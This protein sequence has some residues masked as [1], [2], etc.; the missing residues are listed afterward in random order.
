[1]KTIGQVIE[2]LFFESGL[3][4]REF[5]EKVGYSR[6]Y[7]YD[8]FREKDND[9]TSRKLQLDTLKHICDRTNYDL[10][11]LLAETGY[12]KM[13]NSRIEKSNDDKTYLDGMTN[14][15]INLIEQYR[16]LNENEQTKLKAYIQG[17]LDN[18][19]N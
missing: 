17:L 10:G 11:K 7:I 13:Q 14:D 15:E 2:Q 19:N 8:L 9:G 16:K 18:R 12:I 6:Q 3:S 5:S 4:M 1:M